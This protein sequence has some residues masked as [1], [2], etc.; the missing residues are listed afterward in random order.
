MN[1]RHPRGQRSAIPDV[2]VRLAETAAD[3][4]R[5]KT[6][7]ASVYGDIYGVA[8]TSEAADPDGGLE[9]FPDRYL[10]GEVEG[11]IVA[12]SGLYTR[13]TYV[14]RFGQLTPGDIAGFASECGARDAA[15]RRRYELTKLVVAPAWSRL[16]L[17]RRFVGA[18][19]ARAFLGLDSGDLPPLLLLCGKTSVFRMWDA[20]GIH[21]RCIR[22]FPV[23]RNHERYRRPDDPIESRLV[24]PEIDVAPRW[25][26]LTFPATL[27]IQ[28][29][30]TTNG[31]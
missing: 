5:C 13:H 18:S 11:E 9:T 29:M 1:M 17:G 2:T 10:M 31:R 30:E 21:T 4:Q 24:I 23:Y 27:G 3:E 15:Q 25:Y 20:M 14:E 19:H 6:L 22:P 16:G 7:I 8:M 12:C 26:H 28:P